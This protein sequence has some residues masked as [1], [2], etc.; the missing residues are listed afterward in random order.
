MHFQKVPIE[1][2]EHI[3]YRAVSITKEDVNHDTMEKKKFEIMW[4]H[5]LFRTGLKGSET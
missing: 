3:E 1:T 2:K 4:Y 5:P